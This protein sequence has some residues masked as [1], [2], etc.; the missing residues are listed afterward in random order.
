MD[1]HELYQLRF[2]IGECVFE[3]NYSEAAMKQ[4]LLDLETF[5]ERLEMVVQHLSEQQLQ[6]PYRPGGWTI[7]Q[8][9]H[10]C[11]D[12]HMNMLIRLKLTLSEENPTIKPYLEADWAE[13][14]DYDLPFNIALTILHPVHRKINQILRALNPEQLNRTYFHPQY[15]KSFRVYDLICLYAWH[16]NHHLAHITSLI[17]RQSW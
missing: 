3:E 17:K 2:P 1:D 13:M 12:S 14:A 16:G 7:N 9:I 8:V 10:H 6:T 5:P 15:Q 4:M 11:A